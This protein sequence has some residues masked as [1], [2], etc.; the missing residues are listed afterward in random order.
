[1]TFAEEKTYKYICRNHSSFCR[2]DVLEIL[3]YLPC[4]T[5][6]DQD[7]L[8]ASYSRLGNRDTL[9]ELFNTLQRRTGWVD[10]FI[11][12]LKACELSVLAEQVA[13]VYQS[14]L[15]RGAPACSPAPEDP[16]VLANISGASESAA[17]HS[18][19]H[20]GC[21]GET[22]YPM[23]VQDTQ[24]PKSPEESSEQAHDSGA[25]QRSSSGSV[26]PSSNL[27]VFNPMASSRHHEQDPELSSTHTAGAVTSPIPTRGPVSPTVSF[28]PLA[29]SRPSR[30]P[31]PAGSAP[32]AGNSSLSSSSV[33]ASTKGAS[34]GEV[35][36]NPVTTNPVPPP[37]TP[38]PVPV[39]TVASKVPSNPTPVSTGPSKL[40][41]SSKTTS[42]ATPNMLSHPAPSKL[43][44]NSTR[45][46]TMPPK[47]PPGTGPSSRSS[48]KAKG[49]LEASAPIAAFG[50]SSLCPERSSE[51]GLSKPGVLLSQ[52]DNQPFSGCLEDLAI[53]PSSSLGSESSHNPQPNHSP[54]ENEYVSFR[55][56]INKDPSID[57]QERVPGQLAI[58]EPEEEEEVVCVETM[59]WATWLGAVTATMMALLAV[60]LAVKRRLPQ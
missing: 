18:R 56:N 60:F 6:S 20:N 57:C 16:A 11:R 1:M 37:A 49:T 19:P 58:P 44:I 31:G 24:P 52:L 4:L 26:G 12:A 42:A 28:Q 59:S 54:E 53:S 2:V 50:G 8:R 46:G 17:T 21:R 5:A 36:G 29:R 43:P 51:P 38:M 39:N 34:D 3:P 14:Y 45:A 27:P 23:P 48:S 25:I 30:L 22:G 33:L 35:P 47:V 32:S 55:M 9:W 10:I 41:T 13:S 7:R 15:P 40:P